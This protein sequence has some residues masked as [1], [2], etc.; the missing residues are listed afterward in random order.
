MRF[1]LSLL[2]DTLEPLLDSPEIFAIVRVDEKYYEPSPHEL[3]F[4]DSQGLSAINFTISSDIQPNISLMFAI[5]ESSNVH[6]I[7]SAVPP[8]LMIL[9]ILTMLLSIVFFVTLVRIPRRINR[10]SQHLAKDGYGAP[11]P[12][13]ESGKDELGE[14]ISSY[15]KMLEMNGELLNQVRLEH[16]Q[17][18][19]SAFLALQAQMNPHFI[20][21]TLETIRMMAE[22]ENSIRVADMTFALAEFIRYVLSF[23][24][25]FV[26]LGDEMEYTKRYLHIQ[27]IRMD[28]RLRYELNINP[29]LMKIECPKFFLQPIVENS[30]V[31][32]IEQS[33]EDALICVN[34][35]EDAQ[36][37]TVE[38]SD[39]GSGVSEEMRLHLNSELGI[40]PFVP[41]SEGH[42]IGLK[43]VAVRM[44]RFFGEGFQM[45]FDHRENESG[46]IVTMSWRKDEPID[47]PPCG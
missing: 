14:L 39:T 30:I 40:T 45:H 29:D 7:F 18:E 11:T 27:T 10:F 5:V 12:F 4:V 43:N 13:D 34:I 38:V 20:Y 35:F 21:N 3:S 17:Q 42:G 6:S 33:Q 31:H 19:E 36:R 37:I 26:T 16:L 32:G 15:N 24:T 41:S 47:N 23:Q 22:V 1:S 46:L 28:N 2:T 9:F 25:P 8:N 44:R